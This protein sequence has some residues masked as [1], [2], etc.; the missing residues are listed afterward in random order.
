MLNTILLLP[1][2]LESAQTKRRQHR[3]R[4]LDEVF[5]LGLGAAVTMAHVGASGR[6][7]HGVAK[8]RHL[9][10]TLREGNEG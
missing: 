7:C 3:L 6:Q 1:P 5:A 8:N 9:D 4:P 2:P 10:R